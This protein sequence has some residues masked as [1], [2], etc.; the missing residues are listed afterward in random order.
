MLPPD[1]V[2]NALLSAIPFAPTA[3]QEKLIRILA[4]FV[5]TEVPRATFLLKGYAGTGKTSMLST[6]VKILPSFRMR[7]V[8]LA[9]TGRAAKVIS[10]YSKQPAFTIHKKIYRQ[11]E[12]GGSTF[13]DLNKNLH[14]NTIFI[15]DEASMVSSNSG[16]AKSMYEYR[17]LL[18]DLIQ[19]V[20]SGKNC[21]LILIGDNAQLPPVGAEISPAL[22]FD[23]LRNRYMVTVGRHELT[24]VVRQAQDSGILYNATEL[25]DQI[26]RSS[27]VFP[28]FDI[29]FPDIIRIS[30]VE[31]QDEL[32]SAYANYG[33]EGTMIVCRSNKRAN[34]FNQQVR[35]RI[36]WYEEELS[37]GDLL[38]VVRN[39]YF[40]L[41]EDSKAGFIANGEI[42]EV[43]KIV[44]RR[45][46][47]GLRFATVMVRLID[48]PDE[49]N[50]E[51]KILLDSINVEASS[52]PAEEMKKFYHTVAEDY[53]E[54]T[55]GRQERHKKILENEYF[56][57]L[58]VKFA[59]AVTCHKAQ[60]GQ[61]PAVF[62]DQGYLNEEM[63]NLEFLRW[64]Y[65][66][67]TRAT[68]KLYL[69]NFDGQFFANPHPD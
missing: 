50:L 21:K 28:E 49:P 32:E 56:Q 3:G 29:N 25:R 61:W 58:Q 19:F 7:S 5:V 40:W 15:V 26:R 46:M 67:I 42:V 16:L 66:A 35:A 1:R 34:L 52:L 37:A 22:D 27:F 31:L 53:L 4:R 2:H 62:I 54:D 9:P 44:D 36:Q 41:P 17:D 6:L 39:N 18:E 11:Y 60:G 48:Y 68:E 20:F 23:V 57:A 64:L 55:P 12:R 69:V 8:L 63:I 59:Y 33:A 14:T 47:Y 10:G 65:T 38:M 13:F 30:G 24:E 43:L 45:E 51:V